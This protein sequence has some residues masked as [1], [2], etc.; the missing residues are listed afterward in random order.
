VAHAAP[1]HEG[2]AALLPC[3][4]IYWEVGKELER[5]GSPDPLYTRWINTYASEEFGGLVR[6]V[7]D[8]TNETAAALTD[9]QR[10]AMR[11]HFVTTSRYEWMFWDMG[12]RREAWPL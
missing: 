3:Y 1:F 10:N 9:A 11:R 4:W 6:A 12:W 8:V 2:L 7:L 5:A